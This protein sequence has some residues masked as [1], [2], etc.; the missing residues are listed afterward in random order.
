MASRTWGTLQSTMPPWTPTAWAS[1]I[2]GKNPGKHGVF[3]MT[4]RRPGSYEFTPTNA[5]VRTG[6]PFW[7]HLN[8]EGI[9][10]GL[11]N[12]PF[13]YPAD[14][15]D[16]FV[17]CGFGT[18]DSV[19]DITHPPEV[20]PWIEREFGKYEPAVSS[21]FLSTASPPEVYDKER[22]HQTRQVQIATELTKH[23]QVDILVINLMLAD[24]ANHKMP[25]MEQVQSA[26]RQSDADL[27]VLIRE[28]CPENVM[29]ISD[30]G[31]SRLKGDFMLNFW[32]RDQGYYLQAV[33]TPAERSAALNWILRQW[34]QTHH[35]WTGWPEKL[36]RRVIRESLFKLPVQAREQF[37]RG[38]EGAI[39]FAREYVALNDRADFARTQVF[40]GSAYSGLLYFNLVGREPTGQIPLQERR[41]LA[42]EIALKLSEVRE[43][44]TGQPLFSKV[45]TSE[46][47]YG[48]PAVEHAPD[49]IFD[50]YDSGWNV[51]SGRYTSVPRRI[52]NQYFVEISTGRDFGW[53][54]RNGV[55]VFSG[56]GFEVGQATLAG[57]LMDIP[58][59]LL[60]L[61]GVPIPEDY[62]GQALIDCM[63]PDLRGRP[64][65]YQPGD[66]FENGAVDSGY[67]A[68]ESEMVLAQLRA[69]GYLD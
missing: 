25:Q 56:V 38:V 3:D 68:D 24:H 62:D 8:K 45:Y 22:A 40:P 16:G 69:L 10:V 31:S 67:S 43:P 54:S 36:L 33:N 34:L 47:L 46:E 59:T 6:T 35:G 27:S 12:V 11:V 51:R 37:W 26:Y 60:H 17:V 52:R 29:V 4:W 41:R 28:F 63:S 19:S 50:G 7:R 5:R 9:R 14:R 20:L 23:H 18:P 64:V 32:L 58:A 48:G 30:H 44:G 61:H 55:F 42:S 66:A 65:R 15:L 49:L 21:E 1:I 2:T 13:T 57:H 53:H 39:P